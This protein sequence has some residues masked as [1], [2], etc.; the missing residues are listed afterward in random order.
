MTGNSDYPTPG[1]SWC[2]KEYCASALLNSSKLIRWFA[3]NPDKL[4]PKL[5][6]LPL[7]IENSFYRRVGVPGFLAENLLPEVPIYQPN[8]TDKQQQKKLRKKLGNED[9]KDKKNNKLYI[10]S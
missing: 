2:R 8:L 5:E 9:V 7:G 10:V 1:P 4:H 3:A 6:A